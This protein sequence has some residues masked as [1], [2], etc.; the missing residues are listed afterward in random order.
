[1]IQISSF[2][3]LPRQ[4]LAT[5]KP[6]EW[7]NTPITS[8][9]FSNDQLAALMGNFQ[10]LYVLMLLEVQRK[11]LSRHGNSLWVRIGHIIAT[12]GW[13]LGGRDKKKRTIAKVNGVLEYL[14]HHK[15]IDITGM[16][17][18]GDEKY[19][20][21]GRDR[22][23]G[24]NIKF[25]Y[26]SI[27]KDFLSIP[28]HHFHPIINYRCTDK[29]WQYNIFSMVMALAIEIGYEKKKTELFINRT[30]LTGLCDRANKR[31]NILT[32]LNTSFPEK[33]ISFQGNK[34]SLTTKPKE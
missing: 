2:V 33:A 11:T 34:L 28:I 24:V 10:A 9:P 21:S 13:E 22:S 12:G 1:M 16:I 25:L 18:F 27:S 6:P 19:Q 17:T 20:Q 14:K 15:I 26:P 8:R 32:I 7:V 31:A 5:F 23:A 29:A 3:Q 30:P 4:L